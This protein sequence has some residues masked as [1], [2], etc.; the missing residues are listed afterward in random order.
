ME[1]YKVSATDDAVIALMKQVRDRLVEKNGEEAMQ[2]L[3]LEEKIIYASLI[4]TNAREETQK[5]IPRLNQETLKK[6]IL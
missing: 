4:Y 3:L 2:V 6:S 5:E 1:K